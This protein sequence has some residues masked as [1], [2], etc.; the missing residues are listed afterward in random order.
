[1]NLL[2]D[3]IPCLN[4]AKKDVFI[5]FRGAGVS[6]T[7]MVP[8][9]TQW[10]S[11]KDSISKK[12]I[13]RQILTAINERGESSLRERR[14]VLKRVVEF[15]DFSACWDNE[16]LPAQAYVAN[17]QKLVNAKDTVTR[18]AQDAERERA[19]KRKRQ[20]EELAKQQ[21]RREEIQRVKGALYALFAE[22]NPQQ[23]GK[24]LEAVLNDLFRVYGIGVREAFTLKG[25]AGEGIIEQ[26]DGVIELD[27]HLYFVEMKW[28]TEP[29]GVPEVSEHLVRVFSRSESRAIIIS[30]SNFS[31]PAIT[32]CRECLSQKVV[33]LAT[34]QEFVHLLENEL[35]LY[36][37]LKKKAHAAVIEKNPFG[38]G[39]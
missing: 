7:L 13:A 14:E 36:S 5:F 1:M 9:F 6:D 32:T 22:Q 25:N 19:A 18:I 11:D 10:Q 3:A 16:R 30:A 29:L 17:I 37:F 23:R 24:A 31:E 21:L 33:V 20:Q 2:I 4:K 28:W 8:S 34:L 15:D 26:I 27:G 38:V 39:Y 12:D 35:D